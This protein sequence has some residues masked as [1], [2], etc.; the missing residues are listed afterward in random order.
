MILKSAKYKFAKQER[1][2][3]KLH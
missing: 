3:G 1:K 2:E